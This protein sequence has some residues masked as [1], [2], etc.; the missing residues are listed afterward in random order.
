MET[1]FTKGNWRQSYATVICGK[2]VIADC[3]SE[4]IA[5]KDELFANANLI[6]SAPEMYEILN[7]LMGASGP[8]DSAQLL[9]EERDNIMALLAKARGEANE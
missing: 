8:S 4:F 3:E 9:A 5:D 7:S 1:K 2:A 6:A